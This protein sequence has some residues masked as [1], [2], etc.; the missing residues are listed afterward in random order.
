MLALKKHSD[1]QKIQRSF[2]LVMSQLAISFV[3]WGL[4]NA[5]LWTPTTMSASDEEGAYLNKIE[6]LIIARWKLPPKSDQSNLAVLVS[7]KWRG[8]V[9]ARGYDIG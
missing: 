3:F 8:V 5:A 2:T 6:Q 7:A 1:G 4:L 9:C